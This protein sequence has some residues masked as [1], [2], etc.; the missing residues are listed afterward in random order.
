MT[1]TRGAI[2][3]ADPAGAAPPPAPGV[4]PRAPWVLRA[5]G[6]AGLV[7]VLCGLLLPF[8]PVVVST[9]TV[10]WPRDPARVESTLLPL[11]AYRPLGLDVRFTCDAVRLAAGVPDAGGNAGLVLATAVPGSGQSASA[12]VVSGS[13]DRVVVRAR[14]Q[15]VLD[16][17]VPAGPCTYRLEAHDAGLPVEVRGPPTPVGGLD[18]AVPVER[19]PAD[20]ATV[21]RPG[22]AELVV[23]RDGGPPTRAVA[24]RLPDVDV[25]VSALTDVPPGSLAVTLRVD[26][27]STSAP[28][29]L[30]GALTVV[31]VVALLATVV[32]LA[33]ADRAAPHPARRLRRPGWGLLVDGA[34]VAV[35]VLWTFVAPATDDDGYF[36]TQARNAALTGTVGDYFSF[37][38][39]SFVPFTWPYAGLAEWQQIAGTAPVPQRVP[40][41]VCGLLTWIAVRH[42][43]RTGS[44]PAVA[45]AACAVAFLAWWLPYDMGVRPEAVVALCAATATALLLAAARQQRLSVAWLALAVA[46]A[47]AAAHTS[48]V[49][50]VGVVGA[51]L[52]LLVPLLRG[53]GGLRTAQRALAVGSGAA[54]GLLLGFADGALR[55]VLR[56]RAALGAV[57]A[58]DGWADE[59]A[60]YAFLLDP[61]PMGSFAKRAAVLTCLVALAWFAVL[62]VAARSRGVRMPAAL[63][64]SAAATALGLAALGLTP[65]KWTHHFGALAGVGAAFV[66]LLL[67]TA[68][69]LTRQVGRLPRAVTAALVVSVSV[70]CA[71]VW[72]GPNSWAYAWLDGVA[73]AN[74]RPAV[75]GVTA[76]HPLAWAALVGAVAL[77][78]ILLDR[79]AGRRSAAG[80]LRAVPLVVV[81][82]LAAAVAGTVGIFTLAAA[83]GAPPGS[84][85]AEGLADPAGTRCGATG[86][87]RVLDPW[88]STPLPAITTAGVVDG[89]AEG[90][91]YFPGDR[92]PP[93]PVWGSLTD[94]PGGTATTAWYALPPPDPGDSAVTVVA[95][96][97]LP[98]PDEDRG[99]TLTAVYGRRDGASVTPVGGA[100]VGDDTSSAH[101]RT[102]RLEPPPGADAVRLE[103]VDATGALHGWLALTAPAVQ[104]ALPLSQ[105]VPADT[106]VAPGWQLAFAHPCLRPPAVVDGITEPPAYAVLRAGAP[107]A[108]PLD[109]LGDIAWQP[110]RGGVFAPVPRSQSVLA[111]AIVGHSD[112]Y[113]RV[114][115]FTSPLE[116]A[117]YTLVAGGRTVA[118]A[119]TG[120][121]G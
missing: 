61:I 84:V 115:A 9:P 14:G 1:T 112:P 25:L 63:T 11:T 113:V 41:A 32:L 73:A 13:G 91:G 17:P 57:L 85:W 116:R 53:S 110:D 51:G 43:A 2:R 27:E 82:S 37:H 81:A 49:V 5:A 24:E 52:P 75:G 10:T 69:P 94:R 58:P 79:R 83:Q 107:D 62:A 31:L 98:G 120:V 70:G 65:S 100:V 89:F 119:D 111:L 19:V 71:L 92:P 96:G 108:P 3:D 67:V 15:V 103:A 16:E 4:A 109:G 7:A 60:R 35:V 8:A 30:K 114:Y 99:T 95:A 45:R 55:D 36:A 12:L 46:G 42:L 22:S 117:A 68:A 48:G 78:L 76:D 87:V 33:V 64:L 90:S 104:R 29:P 39:R 38:N 77:G 28:A 72:H 59:V 97:N 34:V 26:D 121:G 50:L 102:F 88:T 66:G 118:G 86:A 54:V 18:P 20:P 101:W 47:G 106:A 105:L 44:R 80:V 93:G 21:A 74:V 23:T 6:L 40:A 56:G